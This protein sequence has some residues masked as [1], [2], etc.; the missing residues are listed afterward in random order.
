M[1]VS[2]YILI[3][4]TLMLCF[5]LISCTNHRE[6]QRLELV[7]GLS[8]HDPEKRYLFG[9]IRV[10]TYH[11]NEL[12]P[13]KKW[14]L[15]NR[16]DNSNSFFDS[17]TNYYIEYDNL[18]NFGIFV[19][20]SNNSLFKLKSLFCGYGKLTGNKR[21]IEKSGLMNYLS[22]N[23]ESSPGL[24]YIGHIDLNVHQVIKMQGL[25]NSNFLATKKIS[26]NNEIGFKD[27]LIH[28]LKILEKVYNVDTSNLK[29]NKNI[30]NPWMVDNTILRNTPGASPPNLWDS[31]E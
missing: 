21:P 25:G 1:A 2:K 27:N 26:Y 30:I 23:I 18:S 14:C 6:K 24:T 12:V 28:D 15:F 4:F 9:T 31:F 17:T 13:S 16:L 3:F 8:S 10:N 5:P 22:L 19:L 29:I 7:E 20:E 11:R